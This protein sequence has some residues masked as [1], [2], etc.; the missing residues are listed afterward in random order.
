VSVV[1]C[2]TGEKIGDYV[3]KPLQGDL[4][5]KFIDHIMGVVPAQDPGLGKTDGGVGKAEIN[6]KTSLV[7]LRKG[8]APPDCVGSGNQDRVKRE[9]RRGSDGRTESIRDPSKFNQSK[10]KSAQWSSRPDGH[11]PSSPH[12][13]KII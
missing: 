8:E 4:F 10:G 9:L 5:R 11:S 6:K 7:L 2:H 12:F 13:F 3:T 1:W